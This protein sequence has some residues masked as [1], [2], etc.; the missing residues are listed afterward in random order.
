MLL[1]YDSI[2]RR[3]LSDNQLLQKHL[4]FATQLSF[5]FVLN[6]LNRDA[7]KCVKF[8]FDCRNDEQS[9][10]NYNVYIWRHTKNSSITII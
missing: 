4:C 7:I 6:L 9:C 8:I 2:N 1:R 5:Y 10:E 3:N